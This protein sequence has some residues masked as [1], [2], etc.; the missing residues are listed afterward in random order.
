MLCSSM[1]YNKYTKFCFILYLTFFKTFN[2]LPMDIFQ[3]LRTQMVDILM[4]RYHL[5]NKQVLSSMNTV[6][7]HLFVDNS[8]KNQAYEDYP[9]PIGYSQT[10]SQPYIVALMASEAYIQPTDKVLEIG[11]GMNKS[12]HIRTLFVC[13]NYIYIS[14]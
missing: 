12:S 6:P 8:I 3:K 5:K 1:L 10:I 13:S 2:T 7:R 14:L 9:L 11:T 4:D